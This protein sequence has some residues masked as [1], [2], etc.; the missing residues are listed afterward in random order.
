MDRDIFDMDS[1]DLLN[2]Q[3]VKE[4]TWFDKNIIISFAFS[5]FGVDEEPVMV[6]MILNS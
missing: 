4:G 3:A 5:S 2:Y 6:T 1:V